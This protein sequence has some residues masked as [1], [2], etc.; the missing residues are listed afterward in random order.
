MVNVSDGQQWIFGE[1]CMIAARKLCG[2]NSKV[3]DSLK[4]LCEEK[5][6]E[7]ELITNC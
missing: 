1:V 6:H 7:F 4:R 5:R 2:Q 3:A